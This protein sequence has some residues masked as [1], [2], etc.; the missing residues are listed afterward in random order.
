MIQAFLPAILRCGC[1]SVVVPLRSKIHQ[2]PRHKGDA[3]NIRRALLHCDD[4]W[5]EPWQLKK[6]MKLDGMMGWWIWQKGF[7]VQK[8]AGFCSPSNVCTCFNCRVLGSGEQLTGTQGLRLQDHP[9]L[10]PSSHQCQHFFLCWVIT[11]GYVNQDSDVRHRP[12]RWMTVSDQ[13]VWYA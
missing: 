11:C 8:I 5:L 10:N 9:K 4:F 12:L 6:I 2:V 7:E 1:L 3:S 13:S